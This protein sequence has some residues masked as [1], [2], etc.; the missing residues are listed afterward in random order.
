MSTD[1]GGEVA[2][3]FKAA[4]CKGRYS[5][6]AE[7]EVRILPLSANNSSSNPRL[8]LFPLP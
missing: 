6:Q 5:T 7:S 3:W 8:S 4:A 1:F 2:E